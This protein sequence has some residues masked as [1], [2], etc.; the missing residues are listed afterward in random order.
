MKAV[1]LFY[2][3]SSGKT[4][5]IALKIILRL[6]KFIPVD[7]FDIAT[8]EYVDLKK[9]SLLIFGVPTWGIGR[10]QDDWLTFI[11]NNPPSHI[12]GLYLAFFG[13]GDQDGYPETFNDG[14]GLL[15]EAYKPSGFQHIGKWPVTGYRFEE[16]KAVVDNKFV[17]LALDEDNQSDKSDERIDIWVSQI[18]KESKILSKS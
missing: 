4:E 1:G 11:T 8:L 6:G 14:M 3:S 18:I 5:K 2:G 7:L 13:L 9:Y 15:Y 16:S 17:G 10:L 12:N